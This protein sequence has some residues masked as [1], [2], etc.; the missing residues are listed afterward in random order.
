[1]DPSAL[2]TATRIHADRLGGA[3]PL[4]LGEPQ[5]AIQEKQTDYSERPGGALP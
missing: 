5:P 2:V 3:K 1:V 4:Q